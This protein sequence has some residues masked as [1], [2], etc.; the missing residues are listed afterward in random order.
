[1]VRVGL[2]AGAPFEAARDQRPQRRQARQPFLPRRTS[3]RRVALNKR[4]RREMRMAFGHDIVDESQA[5]RGSCID[6]AAGHHEIER[7]DMT[8]EARQPY[9]PG[10][11]RVDAEAHLGQPEARRGIFNGYAIRAGKCDFEPA[12]ETKTADQRHR[13]KRKRRQAIEHE[14][15]L[16]RELCR[17][18]RIVNVFEFVDIG[19]GDEAGRFG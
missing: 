15:A 5:A 16:A 4:L 9:R 7:G 8:D 17:L 1:V 3:W 13:W 18:I 11:S 6:A 10:E 2:R 14:L 12:A 19:A